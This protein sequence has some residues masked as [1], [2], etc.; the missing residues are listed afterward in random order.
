MK[1]YNINTPVSSISDVSKLSSI[2][3]FQIDLLSAFACRSQA[4]EEARMNARAR[5]S[6]QSGS[7]VTSSIASTKAEPRTQCVFPHVLET[8][9]GGNVWCFIWMFGLEWSSNTSLT[10]V[11]SPAIR[12]S[13]VKTVPCVLIRYEIRFK[14]ESLSTNMRKR[15]KLE[16]AQEIC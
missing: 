13:I 3:R 7:K 14:I 10:S 8:K 2:Y 12:S 16:T 6:G 11:L 15:D 1:T 4:L 9:L 5:P